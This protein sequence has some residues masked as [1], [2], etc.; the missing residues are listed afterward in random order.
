MTNKKNIAIIVGSKG[1]DGILLI[2]KLINENYKVIE[3]HKKNFNILDKLSIK[4]LIKKQRPTEIYYLAAYHKSSEDKQI[5][6]IDEVYQSNLVNYVAPNLFL[7]AIYE[8]K[9]DIKFFF[10][11]SCLIYNSSQNIQNEQTEI[12]P[13]EIYGLNK[14]ATMMS[15]KYFREEKKI[16][17]NVG[18]LYNHESIYRKNNFV[19]KKIISNAVKIY[20]GEQDQLEIG[21][22]DAKIDWGSAFDFVNA[23][24]MIQQEDIS[25]NYIIS[26][27]KVHSVLDFIKVTFDYLKLDYQKHIIETKKI[28]NR[29]H[30]IRIGDNTKL[31]NKTGWRPKVTFNQMIHEMIDYELK[32]YKR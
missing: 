14:A 10:A 8:I 20:K 24:Y 28:I 6:S 19:S 31:K 26:T 15:C 16:F 17:V 32:I 9:P 7:S 22:L 13:S 1:Q 3:I 11:S 23:F 25:S 5:S 4:K 21:N 12:N 2:Q 27:G 30:K 18:I 29:E